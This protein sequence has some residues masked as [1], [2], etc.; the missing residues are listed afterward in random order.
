MRRPFALALA[1]GLI[2]SPLAAIT[3]TAFGAVATAQTH[4]ARVAASGLRQ[5]SAVTSRLARPAAASFGVGV[6]N[7]RVLDTYKY[8]DC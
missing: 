6:A 4:P 8:G 2:V 5:S 1:F 7:V 3:T